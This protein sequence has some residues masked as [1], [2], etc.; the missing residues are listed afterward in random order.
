MRT[1]NVISKE[2]CTG[3]KAC[4]DS[5]PQDA[6]SFCID[7]EGFWYPQISS[8]SCVNCGA[9]LACCPVT[10]NTYENA[11]P[12]R[13]YASWNKD[14]N[15]RRNATSGGVFPAIAEE[16]IS[17]GGFVIGSAYTNNFKGAYHMVASNEEGISRLKGSKYF[18]SDTEKIYQ[19]TKSCIDTGREVLFVGTPCQVAAL[20]GFFGER[21]ANLLTLDFI[22]RGVPSPLLQKKKIEYYERMEQSRVIFYRDKYK[23]YAWIDFGAM[24]KYES[25]KEQFVSRWKDEFLHFFIA[26][27]LNLR[28]SCY[29]CQFKKGNMYSDITMGDFWQIDRVTE[30]DLRDGVSALV[31][32]TPKG[33][34]CI[35]R[36]QNSLYLIKKPIE[37]ISNGN[38]SYVSSPDRPKERGHFFSTITKDGWEGALQEFKEFRAETDEQKNAHEK[39]MRQRPLLFLK[40][41][42]ENIDWDAFV[43]YNYRCNSVI[44]EKNAFLIPYEGSVIDIHPNAKLNLK[45]NILINYCP[46][47]PRGSKETVVRL[48]DGATVYLDN[49]VELAYGTTFSVAENAYFKAG[50]F[51][52]M[53]DT[54]IICKKK[55]IFGNNVMFGRNITVFDSDYHPIYDSDFNPHIMDEEVVIGDNVWIGTNS[56]I[57]K[58]SVIGNDTIIGAG[59]MVHGKVPKECVFTNKRTEDVVAEGYIWER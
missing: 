59:T 7:N 9:C 58:G 45:G 11:E 23:K 51:T 37:R 40:E 39:R 31:I 21:P 8:D 17:S 6:I 22:C 26:K 13:A 44:R 50:Y 16:I 29:N 28:P 14:D 52:T 19:K 46:S 43:Y 12:I 1:I 15:E 25:G 20:Y 54:C 38:P 30:R 55:M 49:R 3:C 41:E 48:R 2:Y 24:L 32:N 4:G 57:L 47:Y 56:I 36:L 34:A 18:Q 35:D 27:N 5:C 53:I 33:Q 42:K 10:N